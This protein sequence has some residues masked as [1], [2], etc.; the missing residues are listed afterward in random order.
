VI[1][2]IGHHLDFYHVAYFGEQHTAFD[3]YEELFVDSGS[4]FS[5]AA[6]LQLVS[7]GFALEKI[8]ISKPVRLFDAQGTGFVKPLQL[9]EIFLEAHSKLGWKA[10]V[11]YS[12]YVDD[13]DGRELMLLLRG[14]DKKDPVRFSYVGNVN[15]WW[16]PSDTL[17]EMGV[18]TLAHLNSYNFFA[19]AFWTCGGGPT[20]IAKVYS[21]PVTF[22]GTEL[23]ETKEEIQD[24][25]YQKYKGG[26]VKLLVSAFGATEMPVENGLDAE[27]CG[28]KFVEFLQSNRYDGADIDF[29][30]SLA[31]RNGT[32]EQWVSTFTRKVRQAFPFTILTH[33]PQAPYFSPPFGPNG[34]YTQI[35]RLVGRYVDF[36]NVQ[37]YNQG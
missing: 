1:R 35:N 17:A 8:V 15:K 20:D 11:C 9:R 29:E 28:K 30:D 18:P 37:F 19:Y 12:S 16:P 24:Y 10:G 23:G 36:Y 6:A 34:S 22:M 33:A 14:I 7:E 32:G 13:Q 26:K 3:T 21:D 2:R 27:E 4:E 5:K 31:F 25:I